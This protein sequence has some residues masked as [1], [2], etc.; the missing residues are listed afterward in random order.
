MSLYI[1]YTMRKSEKRRFC[2]LLCKNAAEAKRKFRLFANNR[3]NSLSFQFVNIALLI[4]RF[5]VK[6]YHTSM[7]LGF[8]IRLY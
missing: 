2:Y 3:E 5:E 6:K 8:A 7:I 4:Y 1:I